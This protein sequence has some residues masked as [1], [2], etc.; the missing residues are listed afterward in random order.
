LLVVVT[1]LDLQKGQL[2]T[3][4]AAAASASTAMDLSGTGYGIQDLLFMP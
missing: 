3:A 4:R 1:W 2:V